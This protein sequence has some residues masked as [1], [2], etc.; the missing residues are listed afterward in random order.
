MNKSTKSRKTASK[1]TPRSSVP[2]RP[3]TTLVSTDVPT[4]FT[5]PELFAQDD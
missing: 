4:I 1:R 3:T 5:D 2:E